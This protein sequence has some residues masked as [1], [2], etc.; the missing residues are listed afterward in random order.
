[1]G[2]FKLLFLFYLWVSFLEAVSGQF[3]VTGILTATERTPNVN[4]RLI[5][6]LKR[7]RQQKRRNARRAQRNKNAKTEPANTEK[8][9]N[10]T[11]VI[12]PLS[13]NNA[14]ETLIVAPL[15]ENKQPASTNTSTGRSI[16]ENVS[17]RDRVV[18][19]NNEINEVAIEVREYEEQVS[20]YSISLF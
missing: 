12:A 18:Q 2:G 4:E 13:E 1:M 17:I 6:M 8:N 11:L 14:N 9:A 7:T 20:K 10:E 19:V 15:S 5:Q 16:D 3:T